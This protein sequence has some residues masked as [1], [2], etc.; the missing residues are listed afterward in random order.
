MKKF[1]LISL[2]IILAFMILMIPGT[3]ALSDTYYENF[4]DDYVIVDNGA[5]ITVTDTTVT[6]TNMFRHYNTRIY[7]D[8]GSGYFDGSEDININFQFKL[9]ACTY[10]ADGPCFLM[11]HDEQESPNCFREA[12]GVASSNSTGIGLYIT[13]PS[14]PS[15]NRLTLYGITEGTNVTQDYFVMSLN[16]EY[17]A[18]FYF[19]YDA[20]SHGVFY[21]YLYTDANH[22][23]LA[24][25]LS[26]AAGK[27]LDYRYFYALTSYYNVSGGY[28]YSG[29][30]RYYIFT[31]SAPIYWDQDL[32]DWVLAE[33]DGETGLY[34]FT[35]PDGDIW[36]WID[37]EW[38]F[39][40]T[41]ERTGVPELVIQE[42]AKESVETGMT[43]WGLNDPGGRL[44]VI[45]A[46]SGISYFFFEHRKKKLLAI[47]FPA[48]FVALGV[49]FEWIDP[50]I[51]LPIAAVLAVW[52]VRKMRKA[53]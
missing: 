15:E 1:R 20:G 52:G 53:T 50:W 4:A 28:P 32:Q 9:T 49:I 30:V 43:I 21:V 11:M 18:Q 7:Q 5:C 39:V 41:V 25:T 33:Q 14:S 10:G 13:S 27:T 37:D 22:T 17:Y 8:L 6:F 24:D 31:D 35:D 26:V 44:L 46:L 3:I 40:A 23:V 2:S 42:T 48:G 34:T 47:I 51:F 36:V 16:V 38:V 29:Y 19:D 45:L 12:I